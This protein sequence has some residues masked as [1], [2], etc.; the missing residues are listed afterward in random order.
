MASSQ[1]ISVD[2]TIRLNLEAFLPYVCNCIQLTDILVLVH[3]YTKEQ[4]KS[5]FELSRRNNTEACTKALHLLINE[6]DEPGRFVAFK[7]AMTTRGYPVIAKLLEGELIPYDEHCQKLIEVFTILLVPNLQP[8]VLLPYLVSQGTLQN[9]DADEVRAE[10]MNH[11]Q[12]RACWVLLFHLPNR[13]ENW[14][15]D[16]MEALINAKYDD[17]AHE[18]EPDMYEKIMIQRGS[19][20]HKET[21][22]TD[23]NRTHS[24]STGCTM[25]QVEFVLQEEC[26]SEP[27]LAQSPLN[28]DSSGDDRVSKDDHFDSINK[29]YGGHPDYAMNSFG[30]NCDLTF[31]LDNMAVN[32]NLTGK[33]FVSDKD[34]HHHNQEYTDMETDDSLTQLKQR[35]DVIE[36]ETCLKETPK[37][38]VETVATN[39]VQ[40]Y[41]GISMSPSHQKNDYVRSCENVSDNRSL[42]DNARGVTSINDFEDLSAASKRVNN[43]DKEIDQLANVNLGQDDVEGQNQEFSL[44]F[45]FLLN[46]SKP[47]DVNKSDSNS[48]DT[49]E[50]VDESISLKIDNRNPGLGEDLRGVIC[51][52]GTYDLSGSNTQNTS[53][54]L[55][56]EELLSV[57]FSGTHNVELNDLNIEQH[58]NA[59]DEEMDFNLSTD[60]DGIDEIEDEDVDLRE[61]QKELAHEGC[62]GDNV[63]VMAPTNTG[64][65]RVAFRIMQE[66][67][68]KRR[69][70]HRIGKIIFLVENEALALQQGKDCALHLP[71]YRTKIITGSLQRDKKEFL[72]DFVN[73]RDIM[74]VTAQVLVNSLI[75]KEIPSLITFSMIVFDECHHTNKKHQFN[76]IMSQYMD[77]KHEDNPDLENLPQ[78]VGLTA[79]LGVGGYE[80]FEFAKNHM[81]ALLANLDAKYLCTVRKNIVELRQY[82]NSPVEEIVTVPPRPRDPYGQAILKMMSDIDN[83]IINHPLMETI[84]PRDE[85]VKFACRVPPCGGTQQFQQWLSDFAK[86]IGMVRSSDMCSLLNPCK[87]HLEKYNKALMIH[88]DAR[89]KDADTIL[90]DFMSSE[91]V[92]ESTLHTYRFLLQLYDD[93]KENDFS[94]EPE[95]PKLLKLQEVIWN[96]HGGNDN[97]RGIIFV[98][99]RELAVALT[100]WMNETVPLN[101]LN[102]TEFVGQAA[103]AMEGGSTKNRQRDV[104][105]YFKDGRHKV[106]IATSVAEEGL[107]ITK[108]NLVI[109]YEHVTNEIVRLQSRGR[110]RAQDSRY[111]VVTEENSKI[112]QKEEKNARLEILMKQIVPHLQVYIE[113]HPNIWEN[114]LRVIQLQKMYE[115]RDK[116]QQRLDALTPDIKTLHC[117]NCDKFICFSADIR[118]IQ[119]SHHIVI[120]EDI[121]SRIIM[122]RNPYP[123][124]MEDELKYDGDTFCGN[125]I[126][127]HKLGGVCEYKHVEFP[128]ISIKQFR[129]K[130]KD[131]SSERFKQWK[132]ASFIPE[133][134]TLDNLRDVVIRRRA[135]YY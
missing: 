62:Q 69:R 107:D 42:N 122:Q 41:V 31:K 102:A 98:K 46:N 17:I 59:L 77:L 134:F 18:L 35:A 128:L 49:L 117:L 48:D 93:F 119:Q 7:E 87:E 63:I 95:N 89:I 53:S 84:S 28:M 101:S 121:K 130:E 34:I 37:P 78:I 27:L 76:A 73:R 116:A 124:F 68:R 52:P 114:E 123:K 6:F 30:D 110:A 70:E 71:A 61:Y 57:P 1:S 55:S 44:D 14:F 90:E 74:I 54:D 133:P 47:D 45:D 100:A 33:D 129:V 65:T 29:S 126:C 39:N 15:R 21:L 113:D 10:A 3:N 11:G 64:K 97:A 118:R 5:L 109:R 58:R 120:N 4:R 40:R 38:G 111:Y 2:D 96:T 23:E 132:K 19:V 51:G 56:F 127:Q 99:T 80:I 83:Y 24:D 131:G 86:A 125:P 9:G 105:E 115:E 32:M 16:F 13:V 91:K 75:L 81:K 36:E 112:A 79:S 50:K 135:Q 12:E 26:T 94:N 85:F 8:E 66:H 67:L 60:L 72:K 103:S 20:N 43:H 104:L 108:C 82:E 22:Y 92:P 106:V 25:E 88:A